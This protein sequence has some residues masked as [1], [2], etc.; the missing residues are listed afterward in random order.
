LV[1]AGSADRHGE[2]PVS[3]MKREFKIGKTM[4]I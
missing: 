3:G 2:R 1:T 4:Y